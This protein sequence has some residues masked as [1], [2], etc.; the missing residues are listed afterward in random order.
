MG[1]QCTGST[2][3]PVVESKRHAQRLHEA[4]KRLPSSGHTCSYILNHAIVTISIY[5]GRVSGSDF[6]TSSMPPIA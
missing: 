6:C 3:L 5:T 4:S 2:G 1:C